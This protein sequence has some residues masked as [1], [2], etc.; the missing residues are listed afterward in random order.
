MVRA[1]GG[2]TLCYA[3]GDA[4]NAYCGT[5]DD[6]MWLRAFADA[7]ISQT[8]DNGFGTTPLT[9][10]R[11]HVAMLQGDIVVIYDELAASEAAAWD[12]LLHSDTPFTI[13]GTTRSAEV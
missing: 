13:D 9:R 12:W 7:G 5:T 4:S 2:S 10:S 8:S 6:P 3:L 11:R 1:G